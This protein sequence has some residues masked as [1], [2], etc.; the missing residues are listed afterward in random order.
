MSLFS[1][2]SSKGLVCKISSCKIFG[3]LKISNGIFCGDFTLIKL[4]IKLLLFSLITNFGTSSFDKIFVK[5]SSKLCVSTVCSKVEALFV[6]SILYKSKS[7]MSITIFSSSFLFYFTDK[8]IF[9]IIK[10]KF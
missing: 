9:L 1:K 8:F 2:T 7:K 4:L 10:C 6:T 5:I 3:G